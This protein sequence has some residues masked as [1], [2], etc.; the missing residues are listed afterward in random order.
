M[1]KFDVTSEALLEAF[2][3]YVS[4]AVVFLLLFLL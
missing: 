2:D 3:F 4:K 1:T